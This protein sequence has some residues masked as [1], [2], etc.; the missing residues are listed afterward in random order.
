MSNS[1]THKTITTALVEI[2]EA[3][4]LISENQSRDAIHSLNSSYDRL[5]ALLESETVNLEEAA[6]MAKISTV[7]IEKLIDFGHV[8]GSRDNLPLSAIIRIR[9]LLALSPPTASRDETIL[10]IF[11][12]SDSSEPITREYLIHKFN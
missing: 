8:P 9:I 1:N 6:T 12:H 4:E 11:E 10:E 5:H 3:I 7:T 2:A